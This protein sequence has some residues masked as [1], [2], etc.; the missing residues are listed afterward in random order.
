MPEQNENDRTTATGL[1]RYAFEYIDAARIVEAEYVEREP[2]RAI[3]PMP[4]YFLAYHGIE[5]TLKAFLRLKGVSVNDLSG[6][7]LGHDLNACYRKAK[8]LGLLQL[9]KETQEDLDTMKYLVDLNADHALRYIK[10]GAKVAPYW[11]QVEPLAVRLHQAVG[12]AA[13]YHSFTVNFND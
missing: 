8:E 11:S 12:P 4:V 10:T 9:F 5:L 3:P 6:R 2:S 1:A 13:G 7:K